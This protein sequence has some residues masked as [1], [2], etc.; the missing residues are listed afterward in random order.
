MA[1]GGIFYGEEG[2][3]WLG[4]FQ[5]NEYI[6]YSRTI[7]R[8]RGRVFVLTGTSSMF[9]APAL[10]AVAQARGVTIPGRHGDVY[11]T[12][13]LTEDNELT[14]ALKSLG[15]MM[16]SPPERTVVTELMPTWRTLW[17]QRM[18]WQRGAVENIGAYG[19]T[20]ATARYWGQ[21][22]GIGYGTIALYAFFL[23]M[24]LMLVSFDTWIWF[25]FWLWIGAVFLLE[26]I[27]TVWRGGWR[28]RLVAATLVPELLYDMVLSAVFVKG[29]VDITVGRAATWGHVPH[30]ATGSER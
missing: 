5:R 18:R 13:A 21:Q 16:V 28:A 1:V 20:P 14:L 10:V 17:R 8:R 2:H 24:F 4:Q 27:V 9:R 30:P 22:I 6:R 3:G 23:L 7:N 29:L 12:A 15:A 11:D 19:L 25:P 26:R